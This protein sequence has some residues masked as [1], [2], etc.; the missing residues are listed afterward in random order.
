MKKNCEKNAGE[1]FFQTLDTIEESLLL[2]ICK[3]KPHWISNLFHQ[4]NLN[5][6][7]VLHIVKYVILSLQIM[8]DLSVRIYIIVIIQINLGMP[9]VQCVIC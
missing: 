7:I 9:R 6:L 2:S 4:K 8:I 3:T 5:D 1:Y